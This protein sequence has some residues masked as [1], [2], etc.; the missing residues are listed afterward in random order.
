MITLGVRTST[1][2]FCVD[3]LPIADGTKQGVYTKGW[4]SWVPSENSEYHISL[5]YVQFILCQ[6]KTS[7]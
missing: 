6:Q 2:E 7:M 5:T 3:T 1:Y 4:K